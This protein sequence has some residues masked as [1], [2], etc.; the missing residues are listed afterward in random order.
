MI[1]LLKFPCNETAHLTFENFSSSNSPDYQLAKS[2][3]KFL[4]P[5]TSHVLY[6]K[7]WRA[8][9]LL[10]KHLADVNESCH[11]YEWVTSHVWMSHVAHM[12]ESRRTCEWVMSQQLIVHTGW[13]KPINCLK[14][15]VIF[16]KKAINYGA[17]L[18]EMTYQDKACYTSSPP[19]FTHSCGWNAS[20][21]CVKWLIHMC[22]M[23]NWYVWND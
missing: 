23:A 8:S 20:V 5:L 4:C 14:L 2:L 11:T 17:L 3:M 7:N 6:T 21:I 13:R 22:E 10:R 19:C 18:R 9:W 16:R 1:S 12:N 15:Q